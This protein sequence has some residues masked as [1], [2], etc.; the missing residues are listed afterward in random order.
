MQDFLGMLPVPH[1]T[2]PDSSTLNLA[3]MLGSQCVPTDLGPKC[4]IALGRP[5]ECGLGDSVTRCHLD[6]SD[7]INV[8][9]HVPEPPTGPSRTTQPWQ[10]PAYQVCLCSRRRRLCATCVRGSAPACSF[11]L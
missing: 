8:M 7:A 11:R 10:L 2:R 4:Y 3:S 6:M 5:E 1:M 9:L